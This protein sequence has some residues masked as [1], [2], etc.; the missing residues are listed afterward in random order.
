MIAE[1]GWVKRQHHAKGLDPLG[2]QAPCINIYQQLMPGI[3]NVTDRAR[4]YSFYPWLV[5]AYNHADTRRT[6]DDF[7][8]WIRRGDCLFS[9][10]AVR[11]RLVC[12][13]DDYLRHDAGLIGTQTLRSVVTG[14]EDDGTLALSTYTV[15]EEGD[16]MRYFKNRL[17]GLGQYYLGTFAE[18]GLMDRQG[19]EVGYSAQGEG[20]AVAMD[21]TVD[22][23]RFVHV[24]LDGRVTAA[25]LDALADFCPCHLANSGAECDLLVA[26]FFG[27]DVPGEEQGK[28]RRASLLLN[29]DLI[30]GVEE[31][32]A[33]SRYDQDVLR[34]CA[35][36]A[37]LP[38]GKPWS[39][40][41]TVGVAREG[42]AAYESNEMLSFAVQCVFWV[43]LRAVEELH[44]FLKGTDDLGDWF[45]H[46]P[47]VIQAASTFSDDT[48]SGALASTE[49]T[50]PPLAEVGHA[51]HEVALAAALTRLQASPDA[52]YSD[53]LALSGRLLLAIS[54]RN[55]GVDSPYATLS[56]HPDYFAA[57]PI[58]LL[59]I[60]EHVAGAWQGMSL[61]EWYAWLA[62]SWGAEAHLRVALRKMRF[63][64]RDTFHI[65]PTDSGLKVL[66]E[67]TPTFTTPRFATTVQILQDLGVT[68][69]TPDGSS[70]RLTERGQALRT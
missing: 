53:V 63:Q 22:R 42:W 17:G 33:G 34:A 31:L 44:P 26:L 67:P 40:P 50:L 4:Y 55:L 29:L 36:S 12:G 66:E 8:E 24:L 6:R 43:A 45:K 16:P 65:A 57:H 23:E 28:H 58:S 7:V 49:A 5:W 39:P 52:Q 9:M 25:D 51:E 60:R 15:R 68:T 38:N 35:Y 11:H 1:T 18:L 64:S 32:E 20:L 62:R 30:G 19:R 56:F 10:I 3:T 61:A 13:D 14:L 47:P 37:T 70:T 41:P 48:F 21:G 59:S 54:A 27:P 2:V 69:R 46:C